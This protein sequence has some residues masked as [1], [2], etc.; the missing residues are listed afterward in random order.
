MAQ[1]DTAENIEN[2]EQ[3]KEEKMILRK[4]VDEILEQQLLEYGM[5]YRFVQKVKE[6]VYGRLCS[7]AHQYATGEYYQ[8]IEAFTMD[9]SKYYRPKVQQDIRVLVVAGVRD[10]MLE[11]ACS[12]SCDSLKMPEPLSDEQIREIT[13]NA[14]TYLGAYTMEQIAHECGSL[15]GEDIYGEAAR[16]YPLAAE[17]MRK[18]AA[19]EGTSE[20][21]E[22]CTPEISDE[23]ELKYSRLRKEV[24]CDG[25]SLEFD[26]ELRELIGM[27]LAD[28]MQCFYVD[29]FK[30]LSRNLEKVLHVLQM[31]LEH[32]KTFVTANCYI[33]LG[34]LEKRKNTLSAGHGLR[35]IHE[36]LMHMEGAPPKLAEALRIMHQES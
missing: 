21:L 22:F 15:E 34:Y 19:M 27:V 12:V 8:V 24:I 2:A 36:N 10:S 28:K 14:L 20:T 32:G 13:K 29:S 26:D 1:F 23:P 11:I 25:Y 18:L 3:K 17:Y 6:D 33:S 5:R 35:G 31:I 30:T 4:Y 16:K 9:E 7:V